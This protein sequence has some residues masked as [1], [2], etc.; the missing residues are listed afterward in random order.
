[1]QSRSFSIIELSEFY[2]FSLPKVSPATTVTFIKAVEKY[3]Q[4]EYELTDLF[5]DVSSILL[6]KNLLPSHLYTYFRSENF[7]DKRVSKVWQGSSTGT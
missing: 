7:L 4:G 3:I 1:M 2:W 6:K 5:N